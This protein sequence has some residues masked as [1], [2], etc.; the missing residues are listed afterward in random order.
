[1]KS[2]VGYGIVAQDLEI[3]L[4]LRLLKV[5]PISCH[6]FLSISP[7]NITSVFRGYRKIRGRKWATGSLMYLCKLFTLLDKTENNGFT[8]LIRVSQEYTLE[9]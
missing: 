3:L 2:K 7:K 4:H 8:F 9:I 1:M 6:W 5:L